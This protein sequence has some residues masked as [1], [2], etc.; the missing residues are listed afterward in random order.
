MLYNTIGILLSNKCTA[1]CKT[2]CFSCSPDCK[3]TIDFEQIKKY[4]RSTESIE[5]IQSISFSGGEAFLFYDELKELI[6]ICKSIGKKA[7]VITNAFWCTTLE[8]TE[9]KLDELVEAGLNVIS[10]SYDEFHS[11]FVC[12]DN[13]R[14][15]LHVARKK[16]ILNAIQSVRVKG[17]GGIS[18]IN[19]LDED[20]YD[21][22][23]D[24]MLGC[25]VGR[26]ADE[27]EQE[28]YIRKTDAR[29]CL[30]RAHKT[31]CVDY[32]GDIWPCCSVYMHKIALKIGNIKEINCE[33]T[34][35]NLKNNNFLFMLRNKGFEYFIDIAKNKLKMSV[36]DKVI[37][38]CELCQ[39]FFNDNNIIKFIP[40][41]YRDMQNL[42]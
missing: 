3:T 30:C 34:L 18:W 2:C 35:Q 16:H 31:F 21:V 42:T 37:S 27:I 14:N 10:V 40:F 17:D 23:L 26:A 29:S 6:S 38:S 41:I 9:K 25:P 12:T 24:F 13:I 4:I 15:L 5:D 8:E 1:T 36:P 19:E 7:L 28:R 32:N 39:L 33:Q 20:L 22:A 11:E